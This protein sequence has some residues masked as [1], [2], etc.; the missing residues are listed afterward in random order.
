MAHAGLGVSVLGISLTTAL[1]IEKE[2]QLAVGQTVHLAPYDVEFAELQDQ[3]GPNYFG[4][5]GHFIIQQDKKTLAHLY[6][7]KRFFTAREMMMTETAISAGLFRDFY[8]ALGERF[9]DG[10]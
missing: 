2:V 8:I 4:K 6:P 3:E 9:Q 10:T 7:E 5:Q 1:E